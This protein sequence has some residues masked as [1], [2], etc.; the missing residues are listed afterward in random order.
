MEQFRNK[1]RHPIVYLLV[2]ILGVSY[3]FFALSESVLIVSCILSMGFLILDKR[4]KLAAAL[5]LL[6]VAA[7]AIQYSG[8]SMQSEELKSSVN[9]GASILM[10]IGYG[11]KTSVPTLCGLIGLIGVPEGRITSFFLSLRLPKSFSIGF[12]LF[13]R[14]LPTMLY[15]YRMIRSAQKFRNI[16]V[17]PLHTI[18]TFPKVFIHVYVPLLMRTMVI[19]EEISVSMSTRGITLG[20]GFTSFTDLYLTKKDIVLLCY[21][22]FSLAV[23]GGMLCFA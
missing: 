15:E 12:C 13:L 11:L 2:L 23:I 7:S 17:S 4:Y 22:V 18:L 14:F 5:A 20:G 21:T 8:I 9:I 10:D 16:G 1:S 19:G 6:Y 3:S